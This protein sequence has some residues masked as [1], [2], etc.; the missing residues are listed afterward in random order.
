MMNTVKNRHPLS[1]VGAKRLFSSS[2]LLLCACMGFSSCSAEEDKDAPEEGTAVGFTLAGISGEVTNGTATRAALDAGTTVRME[3]YRTGAQSSANHVAGKEYTVRADGTLSATDGK[4]LRLIEGVYDFYAITPALP[5]D[6]TGSDP[7]VSVPQQTDFAVSLTTNRKINKWTAAEGSS[8]KRTVTL[9]ELARK[10]AKVNFAIDLA[11]DVAP[12]ITDTKI[13]EA[14]L[15]NMPSGATA[16]GITMPAGSGTAIVTLPPSLFTTG[17]GNPRNA[18]GSTVVLPKTSGTFSLSMKAQF[19]GVTSVTT[20]FPAS[21]V[22]AMPFDAGKEYTFTVQ[23]TKDKLGN[24]NAGLWVTVSKWQSS[25]QDVNLGGVPDKGPVHTQ[26][27]GEWTKVEWGDV[28]L[29]GVPTGPI[30]VG[31]SGWWNNI[32]YNPHLGSSDPGSND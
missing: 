23:L 15:T 18:S 25:T 20:Q 10:C 12:T 19:N 11:E 27:L 7:T 4:E 21:N 30:P 16:T 24:T 2:L 9:N 28:N 17:T 8:I 22:P 29:G 14:K 26:L 13:T 31:V 3:V 1:P 6:A 32:Y 5:V